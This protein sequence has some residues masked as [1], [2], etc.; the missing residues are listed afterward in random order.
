MVDVSKAGRAPS[1]ILVVEDEPDVCN[2]IQDQL[3]DI[4]YEA[5]C[6]NNDGGAYRLLTERRFDALLVDIN[7]G[8]GT[9][10]FDVARYARRLHP[11]IA[12]VYVTGSSQESVSVH[13]VRGAVMV[14]KPFDRSDLLNALEESGLP[15]PRR[16]GPEANGSPA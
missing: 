13:G 6:V 14:S 4:G 15:E 2:V 5:V 9:T 11:K 12:V 1:T 10:G 16:H 7:L 8:R 3:A